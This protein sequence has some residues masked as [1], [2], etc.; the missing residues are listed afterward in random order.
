MPEYTLAE[1]AAKLGLREEVLAPMLPGL[2]VDLNARSTLTE[3][4]F[5]QLAAEQQRIGILRTQ[6]GGEFRR[7]GADD[8]TLEPGDVE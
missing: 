4:E 7:S 6:E 3:A 2:G 8:N 1:A 5:Q